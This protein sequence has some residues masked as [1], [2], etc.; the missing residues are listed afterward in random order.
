MFKFHD[1]FIF[2]MSIISRSFNSS[3]SKE[4]RFIGI[5]ASQAM[6]F[7]LPINLTVLIFY[8][9][10]AKDKKSVTCQTTLIFLSAGCKQL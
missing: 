4:T 3:T 9:R 8:A 1:Y 2:P 7:K 5:F 10:I 6:K